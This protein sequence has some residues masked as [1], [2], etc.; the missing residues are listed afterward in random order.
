MTDTITD[1]LLTRIEAYYDAVPRTAARAEGI[2]P[3]TLFVNAGPGWPYYARPS[4]GA[5][6]FT[7]DDVTRVRAR[8]R[9]LGV[10]ES[11]EWVAETTPALKAAAE[12]AGLAVVEHPLMVL[13]ADGHAP[14]S[15]PDR[16][17]PR[18]V[19]DGIAIRF[20]T[21]DDDLA[22][23]SAVG[24]VGFGAPG[25]AAGSEGIER[26]AAFAAERTPEQTAF[27]RDRLR[28]GRT[29]MA[30]AF[31]GDMPVAIGSYQPL[32]DVTEITG[33]ATLPAFRRRGIAA[34]LTQ[35]LVDDAHRRGI[36]LIFL[37]AGDDDVARIYERVGFRRIATACI[38]E[39]RA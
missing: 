11:F 33:V 20:V 19:L 4:L 28:A 36:A 13:A 9:E 17:L 38:A 1:D 14:E 3:F 5:T 2:G 37:S 24:R 7:A 29:V 15:V 22:T 39:P 35:L 10:P 31:A 27:E 26:L 16:P 18:A 34:A 32:P 23:L 6:A 21:P 8:Q 25:T 30:E 12:A